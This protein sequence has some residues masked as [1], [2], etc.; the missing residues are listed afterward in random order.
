[1]RESRSKRYQNPTPHS[2]WVR[3]D[4]NLMIREGVLRE[5]KNDHRSARLFV[6]KEVEFR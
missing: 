4:I 2:D 1:M 5:E 6:E 3:T